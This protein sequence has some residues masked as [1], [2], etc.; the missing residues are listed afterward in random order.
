MRRSKKGSARYYVKVTDVSYVLVP[1]PQW[2][3]KKVQYER[4]LAN[5]RYKALFWLSLF[6]LLVITSSTIWFSFRSPFLVFI[7]PGARLL[8]VYLSRY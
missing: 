3:I 6:H 1:S 7:P 2:L 4:F 5:A 8:S